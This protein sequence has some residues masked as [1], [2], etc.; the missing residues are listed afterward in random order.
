VGDASPM[1]KKVG[2]AVPPRPRPTTPGMLLGLCLF[3]CACCVCLL[4]IITSSLSCA[5]TDEPIEMLSGLSTSNRILGG[6]GR[7]IWGAA[8]RPFVKIL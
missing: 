2:D 4:D 6:A 7:T 8:M 1:S 5:N 3:I